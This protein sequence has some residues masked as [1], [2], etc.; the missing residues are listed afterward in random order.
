MRTSSEERGACRS[1]DIAWPG[2][3][4]AVCDTPNEGAADQRPLKL[5]SADRALAEEDYIWMAQS[6]AA[7]EATD[8]VSPFSSKFDAYLAGKAQLSDQEMAGLRLFN[9]KANCNACHFSAGPK[10]KFSDYTSTNIGIPK[11]PNNPY[12]H[13]NADNGKG[14]VANPSGPDYVDNGLGGF[15]AGPDNPNPKWA[16][17]APLYMGTFQNATLRNVARVPR[18]GF[19][20]AYMHNGYFTDL[21][22]V[23]HFYNTRDVLPHC[24]SAKQTVGVD[25]WPQPEQPAN[26]NTTQTGNLGLNEAE[27]DAVVAF[28]S[29]LIDGYFDPSQ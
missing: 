1:L 19:K 15:L 27:E 8:F 4:D 14:L 9:G 21:K 12:F 24:K 26:L 28:L 7:F 16:A 18:P 25:C 22:T 3:A 29:T 11:N 23:V 2:N 6:I 13:E 5:A 10:P 20:R 17:L